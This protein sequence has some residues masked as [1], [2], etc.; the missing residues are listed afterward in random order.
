MESVFLLEWA[1]ESVYIVWRKDKCLL[2]TGNRTT[3]PRTCSLTI[4]V[5]SRGIFH[6]EQVLPH[7]SF[8]SV[9]LWAERS[10]RP[11]AG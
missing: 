11:R 10:H 1:A 2:H 6:T 4:P 9:K 7:G 5:G 8:T 3:T